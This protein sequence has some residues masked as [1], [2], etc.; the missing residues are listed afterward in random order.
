MKEDL[1]LENLRKE[2]TIA[3]LSGALKDIRTNCVPQY[4][5]D[6]VIKDGVLKKLQMENREFLIIKR[7]QKTLERHHIEYENR[8]RTTAQREITRTMKDATNLDDEGYDELDC[9]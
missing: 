3:K 4:V 7:R 6:A 8:V 5:Y 2:E 1:H 9:T